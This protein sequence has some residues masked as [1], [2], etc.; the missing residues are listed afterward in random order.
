MLFKSGRFWRVSTL[1]AFVCLD[2]RS[3]MRMWWQ[4]PLV[5]LCFA[6]PSANGREFCC[7]IEWF[8][9]LVAACEIIH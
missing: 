8:F 5:Q 9:F 4:V 3:V 2:Q 7:C 1:A 6:C